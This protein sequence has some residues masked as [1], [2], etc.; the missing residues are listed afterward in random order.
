M[1]DPLVLFLAAPATTLATGI[2]A[3]PIR[4]AG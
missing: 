3:I 2:V 1:P 4:A